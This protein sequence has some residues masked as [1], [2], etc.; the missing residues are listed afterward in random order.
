MANISIVTYL[1]DPA[2][3]LT[4][5]QAEADIAGVLSSQ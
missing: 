1:S 2:F 5:G 4:V 3:E